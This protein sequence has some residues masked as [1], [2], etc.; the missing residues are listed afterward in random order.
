[1][2]GCPHYSDSLRAGRFGVRNSLMAETFSSPPQSRRTL[3]FHPASCAVCTETYR[4]ANQPGRGFEHL[5]RG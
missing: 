2:L 4:E 1:M 3:G 5:R